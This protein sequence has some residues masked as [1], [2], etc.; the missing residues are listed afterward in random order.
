[1]L[2]MTELQP[3][4][5]YVNTRREAIVILCVWAA[6]LLWTVPYCYLNGY[7]TVTA[8]EDLKT[9]LGMPDWVLWGVAVPWLIA[10]VVA[11]GLCLFFIRDDDLGEAHEGADLVEAS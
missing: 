11:I 2:R 3:D 5:V 4:P 9:I 1:M 6:A 7:H 10:D 8:P